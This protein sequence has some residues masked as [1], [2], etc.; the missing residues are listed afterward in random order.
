MTPKQSH[1][2]KPHVG[3]EAETEA[4]G[5]TTTHLDQE[6]RRSTR[7][8]EGEAWGWAW[9]QSLPCPLGC[10]EPHNY[11][12]WVQ[13]HFGSSP[14]QFAPLVRRRLQADADYQ[15]GLAQAT[16]DAREKNRA[17]RTAARANRQKRLRAQAIKND[18][19]NRP[20]A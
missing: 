8:C 7:V 11:S 9:Q 16:R 19:K 14:N 17:N 13:H 18:R 20:A 2:P 5:R 12:E 1:P 6:S 4:A 10:P 3:P 15:H